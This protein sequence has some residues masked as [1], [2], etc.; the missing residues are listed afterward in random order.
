MVVIKDPVF[1]SMTK[2]HG[3]TKNESMVVFGRK[4]NVKIKASAFSNQV[5]NDKQR[6]AYK[7][8]QSNQ[9]DIFKD[10]S[11]MIIDYIEENRNEI[12]MY[13]KKLK[14]YNNVNSFGDDI[15]IKTIIFSQSGELIMTFNVI[16]DFD[17]SLAVKI[18]P[19]KAIGDESL[20]I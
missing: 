1:G 14:P 20:F 16:W 3:F 6:D 12:S 2:N 7:Y 10:A 11:K 15:L 13:Y 17:A 18:L 19:S 4:R 8:L 5:I 9:K